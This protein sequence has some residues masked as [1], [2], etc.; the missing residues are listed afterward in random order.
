MDL[1]IG[2]QMNNK[3][4]GLVNYYKI[5]VTSYELFKISLLN[6]QTLLSIPIALIIMKNL[7]LHLIFNLN[8]AKLD[9]TKK[10][11]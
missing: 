2:K 11:L 3:R 7:P 9:C 8:P 4:G 1:Q 6:F 10:A 5:I